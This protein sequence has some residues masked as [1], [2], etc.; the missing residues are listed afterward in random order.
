MRLSRLHFLFGLLKNV[1]WVYGTIGEIDH[2]WGEEHAGVRV[3]SV[4]EWGKC[5]LNEGLERAF[6]ML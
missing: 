6:G 2:R 4:C 3:L 5:S 1:N